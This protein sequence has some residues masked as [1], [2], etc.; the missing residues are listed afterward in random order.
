[1]I[2]SSENKLSYRVSG[3]GY[4]VVFLHGFLESNTMW[5]Y[6]DIK[7]VQSIFIDLPGHGKSNH[8]EEECTMSSMA[9]DVLKVIEKL[10]LK[11]FALVGHSMGGYVGLELL[12]QEDNCKKLILLNSNFWSDSSSKQKDRIRVA[13]IVLK[14]KEHFVYE[15]I[16]SL[17][18]KPEQHDVAVKSLLNEALTIEAEVIA[19]T[20]IGM[21]KRKNNKD[22]IKEYAD[23]ILIIQGIHDSIVVKS[24]MDDE[25]LGLSSNYVLVNS[26]HMSHIEASKE[27]ETVI[28][29][30]IA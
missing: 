29:K 23:R 1:M 16:P 4:P 28:T 17:F 18:Y 19:T 30:F 5:E 20:S 22:L 10:K 8:I 2:N 6:I 12:K 14:R 15:A 7:G 26:G 13:E 24:Q 21:S 27:I 25:L 3:N 9:S 11:S